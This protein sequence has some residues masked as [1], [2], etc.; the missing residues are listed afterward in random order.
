MKLHTETNVDNSG[1]CLITLTKKGSDKKESV[2]AFESEEEFEKW[3]KNLQEAIL[4]IAAW[5]T[6][7][8]TLM[9]LEEF[10]AK[11]IAFN[12]VMNYFDQHKVG[13]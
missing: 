8:Y 10:E 5:K 9:N 1:R 3:K 11:K 13:M 4:N 6:E 7:N 2:F 12:K